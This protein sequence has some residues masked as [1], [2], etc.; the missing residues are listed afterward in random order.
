MRQP[1]CYLSSEQQLAVS[2]QPKAYARV[3]G[4]F[5]R[6]DRKSIRRSF[7]VYLTCRPVWVGGFSTLFR[8]ALNHRG[9][10]FV[11]RAQLFV[12]A[13]GDIRGKTGPAPSGAVL[14]GPFSYAN[15]KK[16]EEEEKLN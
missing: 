16:D 7:P 15:K 11:R 2:S 9:V 10:V 8:S 1:Y 12:F 14:F 4:S 5:Q 13:T 6:Q 3:I